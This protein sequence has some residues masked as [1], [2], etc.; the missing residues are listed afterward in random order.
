MS[1]FFLIVPS[2]NTS[3]VAKPRVREGLF[4]RTWI[5]GGLDSLGAMTITFYHNEVD[6]QDLR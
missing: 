2:A 5:Q 3:H 1:F 6:F 4:L